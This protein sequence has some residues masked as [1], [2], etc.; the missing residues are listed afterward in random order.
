MCVDPLDDEEGWDSTSAKYQNEILF[1]ASRDL[2]RI[3]EFPLYRESF[4]SFLAP[5]KRGKSF[6]LPRAGHAGLA[7]GK[8][9]AVFESGDMTKPQR[10]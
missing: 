7:S 5:E 1:R 4:I 8:N 9:V 10:L 3:Y 6:I 2:G